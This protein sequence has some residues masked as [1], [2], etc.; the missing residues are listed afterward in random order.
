MVNIY[1][2]TNIKNVN[3][4]NFKI[5]CIPAGVN[6]HGYCQRLLSALIVNS[7]QEP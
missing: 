3:E 7:A 6:R 2:N 4:Q 5:K 1:N